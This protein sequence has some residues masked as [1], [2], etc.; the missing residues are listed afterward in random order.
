MAKEASVK[1]L[2]PGPAGPCTNF[3]RA[4]RPK[5]CYYRGWPPGCSQGAVTGRAGVRRLC[6]SG[7]FHEGRLV[8][9]ARKQIVKIVKPIARIILASKQK[10]PDPSLG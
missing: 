10:A 2:V 1:D 5:L 4:L 3:Y 9:M 7:I 6:P 8:M